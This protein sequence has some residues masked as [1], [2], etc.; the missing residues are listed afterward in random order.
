MTPRIS[1]ITPSFNQAQFIEQTIT[2]VLDQ[3]PDVSVEYI[4]VDGG[5]TDGT[6]DILRRYE[7]RLRWISEPDSGQG[8][9]INKGMRMA[10]GDILAWINSD[11]AYLP[12]ALCYAASVFADE[13]DAAFLYGDALAIDD[14]D[15]GYGM[16]THI[17]PCDLD[18]LIHMSDPITQPATFWRRS[19][20][21]T[22][23]ELDTSLHYALDYE[24]WMRVAAKF[25]LTYRPVALAKERIY[26]GAKTFRGAIPRLEEIAAVAKR[27]GG[28]G[29]PVHFADEMASAYLVRGLSLLASGKRAEAQA[30]FARARAA[31]HSFRRF[32]LYMGVRTAFGERAIARA[33][34]LY[35]RQRASAKAHIKLP[36]EA[37]RERSGS[38]T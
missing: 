17:R 25:P 20:W 7:G 31:Q 23:G 4:V 2:S 18:F 3:Q 6:L 22:C 36:A 26:A 37:M 9:A 10:S 33:R 35:N 30:D 21:E 38:Q 8:D 11:D 34:L 29:I 14:R 12:E 1:V 15:R 13:P 5:S 16:R 24:Y 28:S 32:M 27:H 19:V